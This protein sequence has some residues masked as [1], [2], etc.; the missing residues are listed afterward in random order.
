LD[1]CIHEARPYTLK[2]FQPA[3]KGFPD[4]TEQIVFPALK[5][6]NLPSL[7][8]LLEKVMLTMGIAVFHILYSWAYLCEYVRISNYICE[9]YVIKS[10]MARWGRLAPVVQV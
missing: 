2:K 4:A 9:K 5:M 3:S 7:D 8:F 10:K 1:Q 6:K